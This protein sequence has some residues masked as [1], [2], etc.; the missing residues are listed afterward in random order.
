MFR[1]FLI[2][3]LAFIIFCFIGCTYNYKAGNLVELGYPVETR[4]RSEI[5]MQ[6]LDTLIQKRGYAVPEK[7]E[8]FNKLVDLDSVYNKR[9]YFEQGPEEM[10][11]ISF[12]GMLV[13]GDVYNPYINPDD[14][15]SDSKLMS[16]AE[17]Q[18]VL[19]RFNQVLDTI[20]EMAKRN[21]VSKSVLYKK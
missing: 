11:L 15:V 4:L 19:A 1:Y 17:K 6:Y 14:Y 5:I 8:P 12:G 21:G 13:L 10:Y 20:E 9:I 16:P 2:N 7:W 3:V 18:R